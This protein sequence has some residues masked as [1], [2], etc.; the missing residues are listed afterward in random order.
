MITT[1]TFAANVAATREQDTRDTEEWV[2]SFVNVAIN[3]H[4]W[5][6]MAPAEA[7]LFDTAGKLLEAP[8]HSTA[9]RIGHVLML[10]ALAKSPEALAFVADQ[11]RE[12]LVDTAPGLEGLKR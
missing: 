7:S 10:D 9:A 3:M 1:E 5:E 4:V 12:L 8:R 11:L 2:A 6:Q